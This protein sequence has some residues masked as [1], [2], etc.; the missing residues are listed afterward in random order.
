MRATTAA[1]DQ[2]AG[3]TNDLGMAFVAIP[4]GSFMM[5]APFSG[6]APPGSPDADPA[7]VAG[8]EYDEAPAHVVRLARPFLMAETPVTNAQYERFDPDHARFHGYLGFS[9]GDDEAVVQVNW[10]DAV[11]F[12]AW[13]SAQDGRHYRLP[14][15]AEW[16]YAARAGTTTRYWT[17]D[18]LPETFHRNQRLTWYPDP[19]EGPYDLAQEAPPLTV[20]QTP[21]NPWGLRDVHGLVE[22]WCLDWYGPYL[23]GDQTDPLGPVAGDFRVA[24]GGSHSTQPEFL[25]SSNRAG[26]LPEDR[27][28]LTGFR[29]AIGTLPQAVGQPLPEPSN[30]HRRVDQ[31]PVR[32]EPIAP[33]PFFRFPKPYVKIRANSHGPLFSRHNHCP[34]I[35]ECPNGDL[36]AVWFSCESERGREMSLVGSRLRYGQHTWDDASL[37]WDAPD[38]NMTGCFLWREGDAIHLFG[39]L[40]VGGTWGQMIIY[41]R[42]SLDSGATWSP[43]RTLIADHA[44]GQAQPANLVFRAPDG[45]LVLPGDDNAVNGSRLYISRDNGATW[46]IPPGRMNGIHVAVAQNDDGEIV[47]FGRC[48]RPESDRMPLSISRD[49]GQTF[50][51]SWS[52]FD[53]IRSGQRPVLLRLHDGP[54]LLC[55]FARSLSF[56]DA[57]GSERTG[58]GLFAALSWDGCRTWP[59]KKLVT[60]GYGEHELVGGA[61]TGTFTMTPDHAEPKGYLS[62]TQGADGTIHLVSS[63]N[64]YAFNQAWIETL[65]PAFDRSAPDTA[66]ASNGQDDPR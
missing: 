46:T 13:L 48:F 51:R 59:V 42:T 3:L 16:E 50:E 10:H 11:A 57:A 45:T 5:G 47:A 40:G 62:A 14:T 41:Q 26:A 43:T 66:I 22:E 60:P 58:T 2:Q 35:I 30:L 9:Q 53:S 8:G 6:G 21:A 34:T 29:V 23:P 31:T 37:Y 19:T 44:N 65:A 12:C 49:M 39:G 61:W 25:R 1:S 36:L 15:E 63:G 7:D 38:R 18:T 56:T 55:S 17:G 33:E 52:E 54:F 64:H 28:W 20:G 27:S 4:A 32:A 24:R